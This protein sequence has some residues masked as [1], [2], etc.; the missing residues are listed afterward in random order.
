[1]R[2]PG[3]QPFWSGAHLIFRIEGQSE[4]RTTEKGQEGD[5]PHVPVITCSRR[6]SWG[7]RKHFSVG[8]TTEEKELNALYLVSSQESEQ[9][10]SG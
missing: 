6:C 10:Q 2:R 4:G 3:Q 9:A 8:D 1:M 5:N 7:A